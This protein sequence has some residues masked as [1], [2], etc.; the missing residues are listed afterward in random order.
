MKLSRIRDW[1]IITNLT[2]MTLAEFRT[3]SEALQF[4]Q[5]INN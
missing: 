4:I 5:T 2:G 1:Y 3:L